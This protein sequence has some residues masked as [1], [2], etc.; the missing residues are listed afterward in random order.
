MCAAKTNKETEKIHEN[1][2]AVEERFGSWMT[3]YGYSNY[4]TSEKLVEMGSV[5]SDGTMKVAAKTLAA[6]R[7]ARSGGR[8]SPRRAARYFGSALRRSLTGKVKTA[9]DSGRNCS[10]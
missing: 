8:N 2:V 1:L 10:V 9:A 5:N 3:Q 7:F 4:L 6:L